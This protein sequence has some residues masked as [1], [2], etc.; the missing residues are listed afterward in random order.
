[1][2]ACLACGGSDDEDL[3]LV[4]D[5]CE[6]PFHNNLHCAG[7]VTAAGYGD[8]FCLDCRAVVH[9]KKKIYD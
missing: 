6:S 9:E 4:C 3:V 7:F 2:R 8:W 1:M 5:L